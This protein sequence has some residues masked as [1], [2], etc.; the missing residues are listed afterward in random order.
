[1]YKTESLIDL[2]LTKNSY[3]FDKKKK[4]NF[5]LKEINLLNKHHF[6][7]CKE[8]K[9]LIS[10]INQVQSKTLENMPMIPTRLF[11]KYNLL[12]TK[13]KIVNLDSRKDFA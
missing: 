6:Y 3:C 11:K 13:N 1:M 8:Y 4:Q 12:S 10:K 9:K 5:L 7:N 2:L